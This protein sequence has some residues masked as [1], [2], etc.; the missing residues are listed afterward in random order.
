MLLLNDP[1]LAIEMG[2]KGMDLAKQFDIQLLG[3]KLITIY[4]EFFK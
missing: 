2:R 1:T 4:H 3:E